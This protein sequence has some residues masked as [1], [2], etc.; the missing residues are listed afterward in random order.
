MTIRTVIADDEPLA[1]ERL[2]ALIRADPDFEIVRHCR[3]GR[4]VVDALASQ[5]VDLLMLDVR[6]PGLDGFDALRE[7]R[8]R[9]LPMIVFVTA[10]ERFAVEAFGVH[11]VDY[12]LKPIELAR[13]R[14][15]MATVKARVRMEEALGA[16][17]HCLARV[18]VRA[19]AKDLC[20]NLADVAWIE[21][22]DYYACL[23]VAEKRHLLRESIKSLEAKLDPV[24]FVRIHRSA[25]V[26]IDFV[27]EIHREGRTEGYVLLANG[28]RPRMSAAGWRKLMAVFTSSR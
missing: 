5:A 26:N 27:R 12:L 11:A 21:A 3:N 24:K 4:E 20:L 1:R 23:H 17:E 13:F 7:S 8:S 14:D 28:E 25:I 10:Y 18:M 2:D 19:G 22:A 9:K 6:M 15:A 16:H